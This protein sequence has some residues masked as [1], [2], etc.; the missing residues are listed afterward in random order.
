M[1]FQSKKK[2]AAKNERR[3]KRLRADYLIKHREAGV[4]GEAAVAN[5]KDISAGGV[6]FWTE[7]FYPEG[8]LVK[9]SIWVPPIERTVDALGRVVRIHQA[10]DHLF[11]YAS[12]GFLEV[13]RRD[14]EAL[15]AFIEGLSK[16]KDSRYFIPHDE[17]VKREARA[18][19]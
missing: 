12:V 18:H 11:Y 1:F 13:P 19:V 15:N 2:Y 5:I 14:Q 4:E 3:H 10:G 7:K 9:V 8:T 17:I 16:V 6:K